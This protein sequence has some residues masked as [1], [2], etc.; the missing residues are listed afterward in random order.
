MKYYTKAV[1]MN[2]NFIEENTIILKGIKFGG[3]F[4]GKVKKVFSL[5][6]TL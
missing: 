5:L 3:I 2:N 1:N 6:Q 4:L